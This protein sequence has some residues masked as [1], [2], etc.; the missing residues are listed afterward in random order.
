M[1]RYLLIQLTLLFTGFSLLGQNGS[2][3]VVG[4]N[5]VAPA[6]SQRDSDSVSVLDGNATLGLTYFNSACGLNYTTSTVKLGQRFTPIGVPQPATFA[7]AGIPATANILQAYFWCEGSGTGGAVNLSLTNPFSVN[8]I[9]PMTLIGIDA[10]KCWGYAGTVTY[11]ADVTSL[12]A[13][14]GNYVVNGIP[15]GPTDDMDGGTLM[16]IWSDPS[17]STWADIV[18]WDGCYVGIGTQQNFTISGFTACAGTNTNARAFMGIG[19]LQGLATPLTLN[20][21][22]PYLIPLE[23]WY[24]W[25][26]NPTTITPGQT[27]SFFDVNAAGDCYN[28]CVAGLYW[29]HDCQSC[30]ANPFTLNMS[31]VPSQCS[32]NTGSATGTPVGGTGPF[33]YT[34]NTTPVQTGQ[35][36]NNLPPGQYI[37]T[38]TDSLGCTFTDTVIV[39]GTGQ[40]SFTT[41]Q[42]NV[43]CNG[44]NNG[45]ATFNP[46][47]GTAPYTYTWTPNVSVTGTANNLTAGVYSVDVT[48]NFGCQN[49]F[50]F[51]ITEPPLVPIVA[52]TTGASSICIGGTSLI[53]VNA[54]GGAPPYSYLWLN[55]ASTN[56]SLFVSPTTTTTYTVVVS[57]VCNT[58]PDT[59]TVT[60]VVNPLPVITFSGDI[61]SGCSPVCVNFT[62]SAVPAIALSAWNFGDGD[63]SILASPNHCFVLPGT[64]DITLA[65]IDINGCINTITYTSYITVHPDPIAG[66]NVTS[67][68]PT[69]IDESTVTIDDVSS[70]GDTC[71]WDMGDGTLLTVVGCGDI[72]HSYEDTGAYHVTQIVVNQWGCSDTIDYDVYVVPNTTLYAPNAFT[73][74]GNGT[75]DMFFIYGEYVADFHL[76]IFDRWGMLIFESYDMTK[77]WDGRAN[78]GPDIAQIDTY[79]WVVTYTEQ[80]EGYK[81]RIIGHLNLIR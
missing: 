51:T 32:G 3:P 37:V 80:Y 16:I 66:F 35:T 2:T 59:A 14:N 34:W 61:L 49:S 64:Y 72:A 57:D 30:C 11:R 53:T 36:A 24:N 10:D 68:Q 20:S 28:F 25:V 56:D 47:S 43:L 63:T 44:G 21:N 26:D 38:V 55:N 70:G 78:S 74:N 60:I 4:V 22:P 15:T 81:H 40:L 65:V 71:Y 5:P 50:T 48:D 13:G 18:I 58:P 33:T 42:L 29:Q 1:K 8:Q 17:S 77:G 62:G 52:N 27:T 76:M 75:N 67:E 69:T 23:D 39:T 31:S 7:I 54:N 9:F 6:N 41:T 45:S 19:D 79:V 12:I 73:P 46:T